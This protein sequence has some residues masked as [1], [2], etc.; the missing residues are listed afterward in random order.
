MG[1]S[2]TLLTHKMKVFQLKDPVSEKLRPQTLKHILTY[3]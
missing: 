3:N 2:F 1:V